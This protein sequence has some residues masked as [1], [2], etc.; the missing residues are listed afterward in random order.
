[1]DSKTTSTK[2]NVQMDGI[3]VSTSEMAKPEEIEVAEFRVIDVA[4]TQQIVDGLRGHFTTD[5]CYNIPRGSK[6][7]LIEWPECDLV[8]GGCRYKREKKTHI[9]IVGIGYEGAKEA[10][11]VFGHLH[12][13]VEERPTVIEEMGQAMWACKAVC[14]D[15]RTGAKLSRWSMKPY[16]EVRGSDLVESEFAYLVV[17]SLAARNVI[18]SMIPHALQK[19]WVEEYRRGAKDFSKPA[20]KAKPKKKLPAKTEEPAPDDTKNNVS[21]AAKEQ[22]SKAVAQTAPKLGVPEELLAEFASDMTRFKTIAMATVN[23]VQAN[24]DEEKF[25]V[26]KKQFTEWFERRATEEALEAEKT[27]GEEKE[28]QEPEPQGGQ[29][30]P[31]LC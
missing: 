26:L 23:M 7:G 4:I 27:G 14:E 20:R 18:L 22:L 29:E 21:P 13:D 19:A 28:K 10:M 31:N 24:T 15:T 5:L 25:G 11:Q 12:V 6:S 16:L 9:H 1:M 30:E 17:Q 8:P 3:P 2:A